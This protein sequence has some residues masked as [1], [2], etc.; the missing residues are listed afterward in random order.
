MLF[1][2]WIEKVNK[3]M[4]SS[5]YVSR[6]ENLKRHFKDLHSLSQIHSNY[7]EKITSTIEN[8]NNII[9]ESPLTIDEFL[10]SKDDKNIM[11]EL[12]QLDQNSFTFRYPSLKEGAEDVMQQSDW[13]HDKTQLFPMSGLPKKSGYFFDHV[14]I[15]NSLH[16]FNLRL[17]GIKDCIGGIGS[18]IE[19][20]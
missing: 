5:G 3:G 19:E 8:W 18:C 16:D 10:L 2:V 15:V 6:I 7:E 12:N 11:N 1:T 17:N 4:E 13:K 14:K 20:Y 9:S